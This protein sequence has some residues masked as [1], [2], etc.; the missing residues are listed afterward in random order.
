MEDR[1]RQQLVER[2]AAHERD[3]RLQEAA[4]IYQS[5]LAADGAD[6][7]VM[8][9]F[10]LL[11][12][13]VGQP[14]A[15]V[16]LLTRAASLDAAPVEV[17][18]NLGVA[19]L[20]AGRVNDAIA[21]WRTVLA[22]HPDDAA[23]SANLGRAL[24]EH[25]GDVG[26]AL[27]HL[28]RAADGRPDDAA[29]MNLL[30][31]AQ[32]RVGMVGEGI[33]SLRRAVASEPDRAATRSD[34][35]VALHYDPA[36]DP[37]QLF[38]EHV[39]WA[40]HVRRS[41]RAPHV[42]D[43][44]PGRRLRIGYVSGDF[45]RHAAESFIR[46]VLAA[47]DH[48]RFEVICYHTHHQH[49]DATARLRGMADGWRDVSARGDDALERLIRDDRIDILVDLS[50]H[51]AGNRLAVFARK[52]APVQATWL[53]YWDTTGL[54]E[55]DY[56]ITDAVAD[57]PGEARRHTE[58]LVRLPGGFSCFA[59]P[60]E[61]PPV[62][63]EPPCVRN[64]F[65]TFGSLH[66]LPKLNDDVLDLW[67]ELLRGTPNA[68]LLICRQELRG[69]TRERLRDRLT[70]RG[71]PADRLELR[72]EIPTGGSWLSVY[73]DIDVALDVFPWNGHTTCCEALF[74][75]VPVVTLAGRT[76]AGR[77]VASVLSHAGLSD[78]VAS[79]PAA[80]VAIAQ[81]LA[82]ENP[83]RKLRDRVAHSR[84]GDG[85][86]AARE[87]EQ[88]YRQMWHRYCVFPKPRS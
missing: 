48:E 51:T 70:T 33:A 3:G 13:D 25:G 29:T 87:V 34:L 79:S 20:R 66:A 71:V 65:V 49:D 42:N 46:P 60:D 23:A 47:H 40:R 24:L 56:R 38:D 18:N 52:P 83:R 10:A 77:M 75:G 26:D 62:Q 7:E 54:S 80:Y 82:R 12:L 59:P 57:P 73:N 39:E 64:G 45:R 74:M 27:R 44:D 76:C 84:L 21:A 68:R 55:L 19:L 8:R 67:S 36:I 1:Q 88:A 61:L 11:A 35:L 15:A 30:G 22:S 78:W 17:G 5:L 37:Q 41:P 28:A 86:A 81:R 63:D 16:E 53:G 2:A 6:V 43:R 72:H 69:D 50:G 85:N 4:D 31:F 9:R 32:L 14:D 58:E